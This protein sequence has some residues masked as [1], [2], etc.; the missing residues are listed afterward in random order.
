[1]K[2]IKVKI[3]PF[4]LTCFY[5]KSDINILARL[6]LI[7]TNSLI[8]H[9]LR[10]FV[11][12]NILK[13]SWTHLWRIRVH[14]YN[15]MVRFTKISQLEIRKPYRLNRN[16]NLNFWKTLEKFRETVPLRKHYNSTPFPL[17]LICIVKRLIYSQ[18][19]V[20]ITVKYVWLILLWI[21][22]Y[23]YLYQKFI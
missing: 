7:L 21:P 8:Y 14:S 12:L 1:M 9:S 19:T 16:K 20:S 10:K 5:C 18:Y 4:L 6:L 23:N 3:V 15:F 22:I 11:T 17:G 2:P 13:Y